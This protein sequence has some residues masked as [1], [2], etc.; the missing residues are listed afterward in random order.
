MESNKIT[1]IPAGTDLD[2]LSDDF[3]KAGYA[4]W[5]EYKKQN[6]TTKGAVTFVRHLET[7][8]LVIFTRGEY[9]QDLINKIMSF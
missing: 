9:S 4:Y 5:Q 2:Q 3:L 8:H 7:G 6:P 1:N